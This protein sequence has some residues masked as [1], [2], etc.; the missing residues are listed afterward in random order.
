MNRYDCP[1][2]QFAYFYYLVSSIIFFISIQY[3]YPCSEPLCKDDRSSRIIAFLKTEYQNLTALRLILGFWFNPIKHGNSKLLKKKILTRF[4][5]REI[6][7]IHTYIYSHFHLQ[8]NSIFLVQQRI[9]LSFKIIWLVSLF[10]CIYLYC[11]EEYILYIV[12]I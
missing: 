2:K 12:K 7:N 4:L 10:V 1:L 8:E 9:L 11:F 3:R 5:L 6:L